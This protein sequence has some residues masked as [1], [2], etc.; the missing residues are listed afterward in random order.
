MNSMRFIL[1]KYTP[2]LLK[3]KPGFSRNCSST[4]T[5]DSKLPA[6]S[7]SDLPSDASKQTADKKGKKFMIQVEV[8]E[9][10]VQERLGKIAMAT[11][12]KAEKERKDSAVKYR[13]LR[14]FNAKTGLLT[15]NFY[16]YFFKQTAD[17][18]R[19]EESCESQL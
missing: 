11:I 2:P 12:R 14:Y 5:T 9:K 15:S 10:E 6:K 7:K 18:Y 17:L 4:T 13:I 19:A 16:F 1:T 8:D 3:N